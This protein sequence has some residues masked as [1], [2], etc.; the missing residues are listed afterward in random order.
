MTTARVPARSRLT[1]RRLSSTALV[2]AALLGTGGAAAVA[3][4][5]PSGP[6]C[7]QV[8]ALAAQWPG[9]IRVEER[10]VRLHSDAYVSH[11]AS[12]PACS[13]PGD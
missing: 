12:T 1:F 10:V 9:S 2:S 11:L 8:L 5:P 3:A 7:A 6:A 13:R 4:P